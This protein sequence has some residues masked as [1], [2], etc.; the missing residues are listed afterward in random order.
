MQESVHWL[1]HSLARILDSGLPDSFYGVYRLT[2]TEYIGTIEADVVDVRELITDC[3]YSYNLASAK[4]LHP[5]TSKPDDGSYRRLDPDDPAKQ[6]HVH[7]WDKDPVELYS[8]YEYKPEPWRPW[9]IHRSAEHYRPD[10]QDTAGDG[11]TYIRGQHCENI[12]SALGEQ[13]N[14]EG[15][16]TKSGSAELGEISSTIW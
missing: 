6:W 14:Y 11:A 15:D 1:R 13:G 5:E 12:Q 2:D 3:S 10:N 16:R 9:H 8:H 4:K 7:I